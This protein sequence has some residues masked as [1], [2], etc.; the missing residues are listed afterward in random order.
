VALCRGWW[1]ACGCGA[2]VRH[3]AGDAAFAFLVFWFCNTVSA[4]DA[5]RHWMGVLDTSMEARR[6]VG[7]RHLTA[8]FLISIV[9]LLFP[10]VMSVQ[11]L[12]TILPVRRIKCVFTSCRLPLYCFFRQNCS[13][14]VKVP[15]FIC[16]SRQVTKIH[17]QEPA[18]VRFLFDSLVM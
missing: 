15:A 6:S 2:A 8:R 5:F 9:L 14:P 16:H 4:H 1:C 12:I 10:L 7:W 17:K 18:L 13:Y 3:G 11:P